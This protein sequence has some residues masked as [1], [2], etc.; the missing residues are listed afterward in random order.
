VDSNHTVLDLKDR[1]YCGGFDTEAPVSSTESFVCSDANAPRNSLRSC[2]T[3]ESPLR[4]D[5]YTGCV[6]QIMDR[7]L[8]PCHLALIV[9]FGDTFM[10]DAPQ[11]PVRVVVT[12]V[13]WVLRIV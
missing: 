2:E 11:K 12:G 5:F 7:G 4:L 13:L 3:D 9:S 1:W 10:P 6:T 8:W